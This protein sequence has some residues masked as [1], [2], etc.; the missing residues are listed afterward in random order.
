[1]AI[2]IEDAIELAKECVVD[3]FAGEGIT[4][5]DL[6]EF[7]FMPG[8]STW[9][10]TI[11]FSRNCNNKVVAEIAEDYPREYKIVLIDYQKDEVISVKDYRLSNSI[12][13]V[14]QQDGS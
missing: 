1:M 9:L 13:L 6:V 11:G 4:D 5:V 12:S 10:I 2:H 3:L 8:T 7:D 14:E